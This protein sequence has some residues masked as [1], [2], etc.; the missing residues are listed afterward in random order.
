MSNNAVFCISNNDKTIR[1]TVYR[2]K[3]NVF[4]NQL[5][6][7]ITV[8]KNNASSIDIDELVMAL[9]ENGFDLEAQSE[10]SFTT[11]DMSTNTLVNWAW[12][13]DLETNSL[14]YWDVTA[15]VN[16]MQETIE[17]E[18]VGPLDY[19]NWLG[20]DAVADYKLAVTNSNNNLLELGITINNF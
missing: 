2:C 18:S 5:D 6:N 3:P 13:L 20:S 11:S 4:L 14:H 15:A 1:L 9:I 7:L 10:S 17:Q 16:G 12:L 19:C 8:I